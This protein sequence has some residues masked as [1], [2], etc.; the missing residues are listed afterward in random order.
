MKALLCDF[1]GTI[2][3]NGV[4]WSEKFW[5]VYQRLGVPISKQE[6]E[7]A[8]AAGESR[9]SGGTVG[10]QDVLS[11]TLEK[12]VAKQL[13]ALHTLP[14]IDSRSLPP[15]LPPRIARECYRDV[16]AT[17]QK[18]SRVLEQCRHFLRLGIVSNF[19]GNLP[20][21]CRELGIDHLFDTVV[22]STIVGINKPDPRIFEFALEQLHSTPAETIVVGD[23]YDRDVIPA[24]SLG[25]LTVWLRGRSWKDPSDIA[26]ADFIIFSLESLTSFVRSVKHVPIAKV[27]SV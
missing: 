20:T 27:S 5:D 18:T 22:D 7:C 17:V 23:S 9:M 6:F 4:H 19:Y 2:D 10:P 12:Q 13:E 21:V 3:T 14:G 11:T 25:C 8:Y 24:K 1:G 16:H 15:D 26:A